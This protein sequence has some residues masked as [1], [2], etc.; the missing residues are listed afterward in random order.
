MKTSNDSTFSLFTKSA[1]MS[2]LSSNKRSNLKNNL[3]FYN[4]MNSGTSYTDN[5][6]PIAPINNMQI[7]FNIVSAENNNKIKTRNILDYKKTKSPTRTYLKTEKKPNN[8]NFN[9][10]INNSTKLQNL[11]RK[12][13]LDASDSTSNI[14]LTSNSKDQNIYKYKRKWLNDEIESKVFSNKSSVRNL[15]QTKNLIEIP[16]INTIKDKL[17]FMKKINNVIYPNIMKNVIDNHVKHLNSIKIYRI[18][19]EM[20]KDFK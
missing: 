20:G 8:Y 11:Y 13:E 18:R 3:S 10:N 1:S 19:K 7:S 14:F 15:K 4:L 6:S 17:S 5:H 2:K 12:F 9:Y 16:V